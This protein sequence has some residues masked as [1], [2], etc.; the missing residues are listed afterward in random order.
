MRDEVGYGGA[1]V[2]ARKYRKGVCNK[3]HKSGV[4]DMALI[5]GR[6]QRVDVKGRKFSLDPLDYI[7]LCKKCHMYYD[8]RPTHMCSL[9][10]RAAISAS[11]KGRP[12]PDLSKMFKGKRTESSKLG[13]ETRRKKFTSE[14]ISAQQRKGGDAYANRVRKIR[15]KFKIQ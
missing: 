6:E 2:R 13:W 9:E 7:E 12:R 3:C 5:H 10:Q 11:L 15:Q 8:D 1:H 14:Q 4:T